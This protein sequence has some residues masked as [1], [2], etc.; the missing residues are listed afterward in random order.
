M[1]NI[2]M[3]HKL[4]SVFDIMNYRSILLPCRSSIRVLFEYN[5][6]EEK[7]D[8]TIVSKDIPEETRNLLVEMLKENLTSDRIIYGLDSN[9]LDYADLIGNGAWMHDI[10]RTSA[11][12]NNSGLT[13]VGAKPERSSMIN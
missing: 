13:G 8:F 12:L 9:N 11:L 5:A 3:V 10:N 2:R 1:D 4:V 7:R 6:E